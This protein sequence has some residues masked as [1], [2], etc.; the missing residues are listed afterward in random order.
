[1]SKI[2][3]NSQ[4]KPATPTTSRQQQNTNSD[5]IIQFVD[6][7][8]VL[9]PYIHR[10]V[11]QCLESYTVQYPVKVH[12]VT[13]SS[14][15]VV[16]QPQDPPLILGINSF[17]CSSSKKHLCVSFHSNIYFLWKKTTSQLIFCKLCVITWFI[18]HVC[19]CASMINTKLI[20]VQN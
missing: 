14:A 16:D 11:C 20:C 13:N 18:H 9:Q 17:P 19:V 10:Y 7:W 12:W 2:F 3:S 8:L 6:Q 1:M 4:K 15:I 5:M